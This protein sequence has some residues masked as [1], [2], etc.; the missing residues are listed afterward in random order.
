M[1]LNHDSVE[2]TDVNDSYESDSDA[3]YSIEVPQSV[4]SCVSKCIT[5]G[6]LKKSFLSMQNAKFS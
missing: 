6:N 2:L 1:P 5:S 4:R 3:E